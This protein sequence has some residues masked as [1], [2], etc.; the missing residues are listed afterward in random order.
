M[1]DAITALLELAIFLYGLSRWESLDRARRLLTAWAGGWVVASAVNLLLARSPGYVHVAFQLFLPL[2]TLLALGTLAAMQHSRRERDALRIAGALYA[3][4]W[5]VVTLTL[6]DLGDY[7]TVTG[8]LHHLLITGAAA[9]TLQS[10][11]RRIQGEVLD[12]STAVVSIG[13]LAWAAPTALIHPMIPVL[14]GEPMLQV[15]LTARNLV[16][17][18]GYL[19][20]IRA[21]RLPRISRRRQEAC[22]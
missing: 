1:T 8:P 18:F 13:F 3:L 21:L 11:L 22:A 10:A 6:E 17:I 16:A 4:I 14:E 7:S 12:D 2:G 19:V 9:Y 5:A 20:L 15:L